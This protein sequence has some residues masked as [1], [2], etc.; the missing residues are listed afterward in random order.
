M[1]AV[2][3]APIDSLDLTLKPDICYFGTVDNRGQKKAFGIFDEDR[4]RH[5]YAVG[6]TGMG[7]STLLENMILQ[8]I[9][10]GFGVCFLDPHGDSVEYILDRIPEERKK[11]VVYFNPADTERPFGFNM[12]E[13]KHGEEPFLVASGM[14]AVFNRLW[15]GMWSSRMEYILNNTLLALLETPGNTLLGVVRLLTDNDYRNEVVKKLNDPMVKN[16]WVKEFASFNDRYRT[17]AIAPVLNK[18]GQFFS[19]DL[20]RNILGQQE[21]TFDL[22]DIMDNQKI[23]LV[24]LSKGRLGEAN[25]NMIG[26]F[27]VTKLQLSAMSR[28][29]I[30][31]EQRKDFY[32]YVDEFQNFT[33]DSFA[34]IL[35]EARK[36]KLNLTLAHQYISQLTETGNLRIKNAIFGNVGT[37]VAFRC[38][39][40]DAEFLEKEFAPS[41]T[42]EQLISLNKT[43]IAMKMTIQ[44][45]V[46]P[47][48]AANT[49]API[50]EKFYGSFDEVVEISREKYGRDKDF[51]RKD[52]NDWLNDGE[53]VQA[54]PDGKPKKKKKGQF[55]KYFQD[56][57][58]E[59]EKRQKEW[60][61]Q[62][63]LEESQEASQITP[64]KPKSFTPS[65]QPKPNNEQE[66]HAELPIKNHST[67]NLNLKLESL[68]MS[69]VD[70]DKDSQLSNQDQKPA[71]LGGVKK[72]NNFED[73]KVGDED[74]F[75]VP[76]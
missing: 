51:V 38:G 44:G 45:R 34:S 16:F 3:A 17:E 7:K 24:N 55:Q 43:Q 53:E 1:T 71:T 15:E 2:P 52:I 60:E 11:D 41:F 70:S 50:F 46:T 54:L 13:M 26:S 36:Y 25:S 33:T 73:T 20:I 22:R 56:T 32:V 72:S 69:H 76:G 5:F 62:K 61:K 58:E 37:M 74:L 42:G 31:E 39:A 4:R 23:F 30:P 47:A 64:A 57:K 65:F 27:L 67:T 35:S 59:Q 49:L 6:K 28:V 14:M 21:S 48:F 68:K 66:L 63:Q 10:N 40:E 18:I 19:T 9:Y 75:G 8:D 29:D 12:L